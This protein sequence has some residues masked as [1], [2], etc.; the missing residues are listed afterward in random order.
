MSL[1][2]KHDPG[3]LPAPVHELPA[4]FVAR[5]KAVVTD[6]ADY[7]LAIEADIVPDKPIGDSAPREWISLTFRR[8]SF[9]RAQNEPSLVSYPPIEAVVELANSAAGSW[10]VHRLAALRHELI[11]RTLVGFFPTLSRGR[12]LLPV[13][14][15]AESDVPIYN[16]ERDTFLAI[17][18][19]RVTLSP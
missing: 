18:V 19:Y 12:V 10:D 15:D 4:L 8:P 14:Q 9:P 3:I 16:A 5:M 2:T 1:I 7:F 6:W 11:Y 13:E 17:A